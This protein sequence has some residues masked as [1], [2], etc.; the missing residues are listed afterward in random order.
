MKSLVVIVGSM[1]LLGL[2]AVL[3][4]PHV[5]LNVHPVG[6]LASAAAVG[7]LVWCLWHPFSVRPV[8]WPTV[9]RKASRAGAAD[10]ALET[11]LTNALRGSSRSVKDLAR[12]LAEVT[13]DRTDL[14][15]QL[16]HFI[17]Q[18]QAGRTPSLT[19]SELRNHLKEIAE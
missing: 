9:P 3:G 14:S 17:T 8:T 18:A 19:R 15:P 16:N 7:L 5:G 4:G 2:A 1:L 13:E 12:R 10:W 11:L 6:L